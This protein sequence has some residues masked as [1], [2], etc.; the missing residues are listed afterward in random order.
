MLNTTDHLK[1]YMY[2]KIR[3]HRLE[4]I[5]ASNLVHWPKESKRLECL[6]TILD[7]IKIEN[8]IVN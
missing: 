1:Y 4:N 3:T 5:G 7:S 2:N 8:L 6:E